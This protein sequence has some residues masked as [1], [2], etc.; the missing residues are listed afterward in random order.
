MIRYTCGNCGVGL[1]TDNSLAG[2]TESCPMCG[3]VQVVLTGK[4]TTV[5][6]EQIVQFDRSFD[7]SFER[8][9]SGAIPGRISWPMR[10]ACC[11]QAADTTLKLE[12]S[13]SH[14]SGDRQVTETTSIHAPYCRDCREHCEMRAKGKESFTNGLVSFVMGVPLFAVLFL[15]LLG[16]GHRGGA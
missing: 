8:L 12:Y 14:S 13:V 7:A 1:E 15:A 16:D 6:V 11:G 10:C 3:H 2:K 5:I 4:K 9:K